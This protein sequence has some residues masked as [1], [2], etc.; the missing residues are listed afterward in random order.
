MVSRKSIVI[1]LV[2]LTVGIVAISSFIISK[3]SASV[4]A[5]SL[6]DAT[7]D[8][9][10]IVA[11]NYTINKHSVVSGTPSVVLNRLV[12]ASDLES[13]GFGHIGVLSKQQQMRFIILKGDLDAANV[14]VGT[15]PSSVKTEY[16]GY[17]FDLTLNEPTGVMVSPHGAAF[18]K[19]LN[20]PNLPNDNDVVVPTVNTSTSSISVTPTVSDILAQP[21]YTANVPN[22]T[23]P[24][25]QPTRK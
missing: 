13:L 25:A 24:I 15:H 23:P 14:M 3:T 10:A 12:T 21:N 16:I 2:L 1:A 17:I 9:V 8:E 18:R 7:P 6:L 4:P 11:V 19:A 5:S 22:A 20:N